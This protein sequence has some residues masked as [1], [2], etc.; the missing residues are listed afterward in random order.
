MDV[1]QIFIFLLLVSLY[2]IRDDK[3]WVPWHWKRSASEELD[4][5]KRVTE[6]NPERRRGRLR[7]VDQDL[8]LSKANMENFLK[9]LWEWLK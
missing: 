6:P 7:R 4:D 1:L 8:G 9:F 2:H 3:T 5:P